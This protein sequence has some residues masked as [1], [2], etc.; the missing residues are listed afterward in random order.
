[1]S[2]KN[3]PPGLRPFCEEFR[4]IYERVAALSHIQRQDFCE[5]VSVPAG[6]RTETTEPLVGA[7]G[8]QLTLNHILDTCGLFMPA[9]SAS[10]WRDGSI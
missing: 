1:M 5:P 2:I 9:R 7:K 8:I 10:G 6:A 4:P 3:K